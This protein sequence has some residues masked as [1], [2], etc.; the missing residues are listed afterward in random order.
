MTREEL[1]AYLKPF[2]SQN[3]SGK[4]VITFKDGNIS[5]RIELQKTETVTVKLWS[6]PKAEY[7][8]T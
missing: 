7:Q 6:K 5:R 8:L 4:L 1:S 2:E 3:F